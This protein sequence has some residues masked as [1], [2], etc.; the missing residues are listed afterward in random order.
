VQSVFEAP[1]P[2]KPRVRQSA[3]SSGSGPVSAPEVLPLEDEVEPDVVPV[4][5]VVGDGPSSLRSGRSVS[6]PTI[7]AQAGTA[8]I[9]ASMETETVVNRRTGR[10]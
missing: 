3:Q 2:V 5:V 7:E 1:Q 9:P 4:G 6:M 10:S 8:T